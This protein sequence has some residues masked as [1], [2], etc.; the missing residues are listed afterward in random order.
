MAHLATWQRLPDDIKSV[1]ERN[2][3]AHVRQ[4]RLDHAAL[5][6]SL[7]QDLARRGLLFNEVEQA[8]FRAKLTGVYGAWRERLGTRCWSLLEAEVGKLG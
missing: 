3:T 4:Q 8:A 2:V 6:A 7:R 1:I 5:N